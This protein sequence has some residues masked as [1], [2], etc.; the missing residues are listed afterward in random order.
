MYVSDE[1]LAAQIVEIGRRLYA[2]GYIVAGDGNVSA[3][4]FD[5]NILITPRAVNKGFLTTD[6]IVK[7]TVNGDHVSGRLRSSSEIAMHLAIY[8]ERPDVAAVVHA[9]P[10]VG[11]GFAAAGLPLDQAMVSEVVLT[12]GCIPLA[13]YGTPSTEELPQAIR[14]LCGNY[15]ALLLANHGAVAYGPDLETAHGRME[16]L[17]HFAR[18]S[19]VAHLLGGGKPIPPNEVAKLIDVR[20]RAGLMGPERRCQVCGT[21][22]SDCS[23]PSHGPANPSRP[24]TDGGDEVIQLTRRELIDLIDRAT[25]LALD[26]YSEQ[27]HLH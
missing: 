9:H 10:P 18:I 11:T 19:L 7:T 20:E 21:A 25:R 24:G 12:L 16:T 2:Q 17:E 5:G 14:K 3:R 26:R 15:D 4:T 22:N 27:H 6:M 1:Q 8:Q 13:A 23:S